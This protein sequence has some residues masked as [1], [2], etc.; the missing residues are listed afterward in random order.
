MR[1]RHWGT[2][3]D[4]RRCVRTSSWL[5][6]LV[7]SPRQASRST[8][9]LH[10]SDGRGT[11]RNAQP[12]IPIAISHSRPTRDVHSTHYIRLHSVNSH[13]PHLLPQPRHPPTVS[14]YFSP[15]LTTGHTTWTTLPTLRDATT[16]QHSTI[17]YNR[18]TEVVQC[19]E[20]CLEFVFVWSEDAAA[21]GGWND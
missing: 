3:D 6:R 1:G 2:S 7:S 13:S 14:I 21:L 18:I 8:A 20:V 17:Q 11:A 4:R 5:H 15:F 10:H 19:H 16:T 12:P 9:G